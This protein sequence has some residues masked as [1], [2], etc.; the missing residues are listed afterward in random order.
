[1]KPKRP[2]SSKIFLVAMIPL[3]FELSF[4]AM[5]FFLVHH[6]EAERGAEA[7][8]AKIVAQVNRC[9]ADIIGSGMYFVIFQL[10][11]DEKPRQGVLESGANLK[12]DLADLEQL[13]S[14]DEPNV[15]ASVDNFVSQ[16]KASIDRMA[17]APELNADSDVGLESASRFKQAF[18]GG[19]TGLGAMNF[20]S[21]KFIMEMRKANS[22]ITQTGREIADEQ[23]AVRA[24]RSAAEAALRNQINT[25]LQCGVVISCSLSLALALAFNFSIARRVRFVAENTNRFA[26]GEELKQ[27]LKG[28]DEIAALDQSFAKMLADL[29]ET[30]RREGAV[31]NNAADVIC[32]LDSDGR[33]LAVNPACEKFWGYPSVDLINKLFKDKLAPSEISSFESEL[34]RATTCNSASAFELCVTRSDGS[35]CYTL[36]SATYLGDDRTIVCIVH[37]ITDRRQMERLKREFS[38]ML[39]D[40]LR[41]PLQEMQTMLAQLEPRAKEEISEKAHKKLKTAEAEVNR[42]ITLV[43]ELSKL[44]RVDARSSIKGAGEARRPVSVQKVIEQTVASVSDFAADKNIALVAEPSAECTFTAVEEDIVRVLVNLVSNAVKFSP[45]ATTVRMSCLKNIEKGTVEFRVADP[46]QL[47]HA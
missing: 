19:T 36:W 38:S 42:L 29:K 10:T 15:K 46:Y 18:G 20:R 40:D 16:A 12:R 27:P 41:N 2:L 44:D 31:I 33:V 8:A 6:A 30:R 47:V 43:G 1:M 26:A 32:T 21:L 11:S 25:L 34:L 5:L 24:Q 37:D 28:D 22:E 13:C 14:H 4:M 9:V 23:L 39:R 45:S 3:C 35:P 7:H 17:E